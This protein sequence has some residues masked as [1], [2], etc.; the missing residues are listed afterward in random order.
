MQDN[1]SLK[2]FK[3]DSMI[4]INTA[5]E[6]KNLIEEVKS[7]LVYRGYVNNDQLIP[8]ISRYGLED[9]EHQMLKE[10]IN[11]P[12]IQKKVSLD[13]LSQVIE[14]AQHYGIPTRFLDWSYDIKVALYFALEWHKENDDPSYI[15]ILHIN[16][17]PN[18]ENIK[19]LL[20][21]IDP[22]SLEDLDDYT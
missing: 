18:V 6:V 8:T 20:E 19:T 16:D 13:T 15:G 12:V 10:F 4:V 3:G 7:G 21:D 11:L 17:I 2:M 22:I 9:L 5:E 14:L 1:T